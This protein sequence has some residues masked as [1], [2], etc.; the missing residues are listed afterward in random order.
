[1]THG[2]DSPLPT[3]F[4]QALVVVAV[5]GAAA[6]ATPQEASREPAPLAA[7]H[8]SGAP[9]TPASAGGNAA[10]FTG[11]VAETINSGGYTYIRLQSGGKDV[12]VAATEIPVKDGESLTVAL[13]MPMENFHSTTLDRD[14]PLVYF[15]SGVAREGQPLPAAAIAPGAAPPMAAAAGAN[16][17]GAAGVRPNAPPAGGL[18]I[19]DVWAKRASLS[20]TGVTVRGTVVK[21]NNGI[22]G[23]NWFHLQDGS[24]SAS[25]GTN[26]LTVT[27]D[28][29]VKVGDVVTVSGTLATKKD[30]GAGYSY[31]AILENATVK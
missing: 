19:A 10:V 1:M 12:W 8:A 5:A 4:C 18:A 26:D 7:S 11:T 30:F 9:S 27:T 14:F 22:M 2:I 24:G 21:V 28:A 15:V 13:D 20:G 31:E 23:L 16:Q 6:C 25:D 29:Q 17:S 3:R